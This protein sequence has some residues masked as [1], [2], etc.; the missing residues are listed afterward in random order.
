[1]HG[2]PPGTLLIFPGF[3]G[4]VERVCRV[5]PHLCSQL[6]LC[7]PSLGVSPGICHTLAAPPSLYLAA[8][9]PVY[10]RAAISVPALLILNVGL[11]QSFVTVN[12]TV[13]KLSSLCRSLIR[14]IR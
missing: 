12:N 10:G 7:L 9:Y 11:F 1:M 2:R 3:P 13:T 6:Q 14:S 8:Y 5:T 4:Q